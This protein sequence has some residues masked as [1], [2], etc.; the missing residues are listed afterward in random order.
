VD[1]LPTT[2][3]DVTMEDLGL[4]PSLTEK[5]IEEGFGTVGELMMQLELD[6]DKILAINGV[7]PKAMEDIEAAIAVFDFPEPEP[8][9][10]PEPEAVAE[11]EMGIVD[12]VE[13]TEEAAEADA[14]TKPEAEEPQAEA[15]AEADKEPE[16]EP[17]PQ[18]VEAIFAQTEEKLLGKQRKPRPKQTPA[19]VEDLAE[20]EGKD[21]GKKKKKKKFRELEYDPD[22]DVTVVKRRREDWEGEDW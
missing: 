9:P 21:T 20:A 7:G 12:D 3:F 19:T 8:E 5:V 14:E 22:H 17:E 16:E 10:D 1:S 2:A 11:A 15:E 6:A 18:S 4:T 13:A